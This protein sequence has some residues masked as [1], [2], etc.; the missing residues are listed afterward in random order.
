MSLKD[1]LTSL[2]NTSEEV[3]ESMRKANVKGK[4]CDLRMCPIL[5]AIYTGPIKDK[6]W[7]GL[8][9]HGGKKDKEGKRHYN[10]TY[11]DCQIMDPQLPR[12]VQDFIADFDDG[13]YPDL[14][15]KKVADVTTRVWE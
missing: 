14:E 7:S 8:I 1:Y 9:I 4:R 12:P 10:A 5:N 6:V 11:N 15:A 3:A 2:G 13:K